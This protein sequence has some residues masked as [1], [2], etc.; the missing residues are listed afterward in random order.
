LPSPLL[1]PDAI[2]AGGNK[3]MTIDPQTPVLIGVGQRTVHWR[4]PD[5]GPAPSP[6]ALRATAAR[7]ALAD[8]VAD[9]GT[10]ADLAATIDRVVVV[11]TMLDSVPGMPQ[12]FGRCANPPGTLA[13]D[14]GVAPRETIYSMVGGD[15]PQALVNES[16]SAIHAGEARAILLA[17]AEAT[18]A[19]KVAARHGAMLDWSASA[20]GACDDRGLGPMLLSPYA[21]ANGLGAPTQTYPAFEHA[22][23]ARAGHS[24]ADHRQAMSALWSQFSAVAAA[25]MR[26][27]RSLAMPP[28]CRR[29]R[30]KITRSPIPISNGMSR[31]MR[32][33]RGRR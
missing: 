3:A 17:G 18:A 11:R 8:A 19:M 25:P 20:E 30:P 23:R 4:G 22:Y 24:V 31:R 14:I 6:Q 9:G 33:T 15:Q 26:N 29:H 27:S 2:G 10:A 1:Y 7:L 21:L 13:A 12:P 32:S 28:S 5:D 16:A